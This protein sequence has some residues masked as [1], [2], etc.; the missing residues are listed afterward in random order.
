M[1]IVDLQ[2]FLAVPSLTVY[3]TY[4]PAYFGPLFGPLSVK[5]ATVGNTFYVRQTAG[6]HGYSN[7]DLKSTQATGQSIPLDARRDLL[8]ESL[9]NGELQLFAIWESHDVNQLIEM[10][11][12][13]EPVS[14]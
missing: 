10:L 5:G 2:T 14:Y 3:T 7:N 11:I 4:D 13:S 8:S 12:A 1:K 6:I 9:P